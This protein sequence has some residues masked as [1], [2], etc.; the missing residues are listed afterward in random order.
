MNLGAGRKFYIKTFGCQMNMHD[1]DRMSALLSEQ[2]YEPA[3]VMESADLVLF[4]S[5]AIRDKSEQKAYSSMGFLRKGAKKKNPNLKIGFTGCVAQQDRDEVFQGAPQLDFVIGTDS[6]DQLPE[7]LHRVE[8]GEKKV[9]Q[10]GFDPSNDYSLETKV[11]PGRSLAYVNIMKGCD[12]FC[13]YCIVPFTRGREKS[14][15]LEEILQD[16]KRLVLGGVLEITLLGQNVNSYGKSL[17]GRAAGISFPTLLRALQEMADG[18]DSRGVT[19]AMGRSGKPRGLRHIRYTT[20]HP[21]DFD[22][23]MIECHA[24]LSP[25]APPAFAGAK[26][27]G[28]HFETHEALCAH[29]PIFSA[30]R[31]IAGTSA[32]YCNFHGFDRGVSRRGRK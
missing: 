27:L 6:I 4:N 30:Y 29:F 5:C 14:R 10:V 12:N 17:G 23:E 19:D 21:K 3:E 26:R 8:S 15:R 20:S 9:I 11:L 2:G 32:G 28:P 24:T 31:K 18:L 1:T 25:R 16:V 13:S 22:E 7:V